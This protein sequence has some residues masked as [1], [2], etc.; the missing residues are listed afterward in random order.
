MESISSALDELYGARIE[1]VIR[2]KGELHCT[3]LYADFPDDRFIEGADGILEQTVSMLGGILL[4]PALK[5]DLLRLVYV[6]SEKTNLIDDIRA[7][8]N[9][10]RGYTINRLLEEM[11]AGEAYGVRRLGRE[12]EALAIT[13]ETLTA[14]YR[15]LLSSSQIEVF[16]CGP[17]ESDRVGSIL[18]DTF[19]NLQERVCTAVPETKII[20]YPDRKPPR[21]FSEKLDVTQGKLA[22]GFR[23][24]KAMSGLPDLPALMVFNAVYGSGDT[25]KLFLNVRERLSLCYYA[26]SRIDRHKGVMIVSSGVEFDML[27][28]ALEEIMAQLGYIKDGDIRDWELTSAKR[29]VAASVKQ[30]MDRP[31][32]LEDLYFDSL[33]SKFPYDPADLCDMVEDVTIDRVVET[34]SEI[35]ADS[36]YFLS[37]EDEE[38]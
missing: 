25:S 37:G 16:Y 27:D 29:S 7:A 31:G 6:D 11:C 36:V 1:P 2:K 20:L 15:E 35:E 12:E 28:A 5:D 10:K 32:G 9:D 14:H 4:S 33:I 23:L 17:A 21:R 13:P 18:S 34:A 26:G 19:K 22:V 30:A 38:L 3:G 24:G 8:V